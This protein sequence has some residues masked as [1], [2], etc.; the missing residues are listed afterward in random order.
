M[1]PPA[2]VPADVWLRCCQLCNAAYAAGPETA[3]GWVAGTDDLHCSWCEMYAADWRVVHFQFRD[4][5]DT[6][7]KC[8]WLCAIPWDSGRGGP[9]GDEA[10]VAFKGSDSIVDVLLDACVADMTTAGG[11]HMH[12]GAYVAVQQEL[13]S[14]AAAISSARA[15]AGGTLRRVVFTGHSLGGACAVATALELT[16]ECA[17]PPWH[18]G[19]EAEIVTFGSPLILSDG[20]AGARRLQLPTPVPSSGVP[21]THFVNGFD[22]VPRLLALPSEG[23]A[24]WARQVVA[25]QV[26]EHVRGIPLVGKQVRTSLKERSAPIATMLA[27]ELEKL[28]SFR[29]YGTYVFVQSVEVKPGFDEVSASVAAAHRRTAVQVI[30]AP[31]GV[32]P[33]LVAEELLSYLPSV[34]PVSHCPDA[35]AGGP[36]AMQLGNL[37][38]AEHSVTTGYFPALRHLATHPEY[39]FPQ[40]SA[41]LPRSPVVPAAPRA[42]ERRTGAAAAERALRLAIDALESEAGGEAMEHCRSALFALSNGDRSPELRTPPSSSPP[43]RSWYLPK[44]AS[45]VRAVSGVA[46]TAAAASV[47]CIVS[48]ST[49]L[50]P[51]CSTLNSIKSARCEVCRAK[52]K[53]PAAKAAPPA[54]DDRSIRISNHLPYAV[55]V[56]PSA[57]LGARPVLIKRGEFEEVPH[58]T[59]PAALT[60]APAPEAEEP[61]YGWR[62]GQQDD[63]F[64]FVVPTEVDAAVI[65]SSG[66]LGRVSWSFVPAAYAPP[67]QGKAEGSFQL[68]RLLRPQL[69]PPLA[70][71]DGPV[72]GRLST[73][74]SDALV[75][76]LHSLGRQCEAAAEDAGGCVW[77][78]VRR[79]SP[80]L[81]AAV[82]ALALAVA[83][84]H[85]AGRMAQWTSSSS[86]S[87]FVLCCGYNDNGQLGVGNTD[88]QDHFR[89]VPGVSEILDVDCASG[90][91]FLLTRSGDLLATGRNKYGNLGLGHTQSV[92]K[93]VR[94]PSPPGG[95]KV[96]KISAGYHHTI[97]LM[98]DGTV[99]A[100]GRNTYGELGMGHWKHLDRLEQVQL[101][102]DGMCVTHLGAGDS[103]SLVAAESTRVLTNSLLFAWGS[104]EGQLGLRDT[105]PR[106]NPTA[107]V[108][109]ECLRRIVD[110]KVGKSHVLLLS[111]D[112][113]VYAAG[114]NSYGC[115]GLGND[116]IQP[117]FQRVRTLDDYRVFG[118]SCGYYH[119]FA[120]TECGKVFACGYN[121]SGEL[122]LGHTQHQHKFVKVST[123]SNTGVRKVA[124]GCYYT[125]VLLDSGQVLGA[126]YNKVCNLGIARQSMVSQFTGIPAIRGVAC[127]L[128]PS[129]FNYNTFVIARGAIQVSRSSTPSS[130]PPP[131][132]SGADDADEREPPQAC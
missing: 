130:T 83:A 75:L 33:N 113:H 53:A 51:A 94:V 45:A 129:R 60:V 96:H 110:L 65:E 102:T 11:A 61:C 9:A 68:M 18:P 76:L 103:F 84:T 109:P 85:A 39:W 7:H 41:P 115:C 112:G 5:S 67:T 52:Y 131:V 88:E 22:I 37:S 15:A 29:A 13:R 132:D 56:S 90:D 119:S 126:G 46:C 55:H 128:R 23:L 42:H 72:A 122:G 36:V 71:A 104:N 106:S 25:A 12:S 123:L 117:A 87:I 93:F 31:A 116:T 1:D 91:S 100:A 108:L 50:C 3:G 73:R 82:A 48:G 54:A 127:D 121:S 47:A 16:A 44:C 70:T 89:I 63:G 118:I 105:E 101:P 10:Y 66:L 98:S 30:P 59:G 62:R 4:V 35:V 114:R 79:Y 38:V 111:S 49:W 69:P 99:W 2:T 28:R 27:K 21:Q 17:S 77:S 32:V 95:L 43:P 58:S 34:S 6:L 107:V 124:C 14:I 26:D 40:E 120:H 92:R 19:L 74:M 64:T 125:L 20:S 78:A 80:A 86:P 8:Q 81:D 24:E 57:P 97:V